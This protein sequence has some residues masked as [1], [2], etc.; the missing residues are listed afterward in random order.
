MRSLLV[1]LLTILFLALPVSAL[2]KPGLWVA[3]SGASTL[4]LFGTV[5]LLPGHTDW[6][7][8]ALDKALADSGTLYIEIT[9]DNPLSVQVLVLKYGIDWQNTLSSQLDPGDQAR[10][11]HVSAEAG[12]SLATLE[13]MR[14]WLAGLTLTMAPLLKAGLDPKQG[15]DKQLKAQFEAAGKPVKGLETSEQQIRFFA[16]MPPKLQ[17]KF[18]HGALKDYGKVRKELATLVGYWDAGDVAAIARTADLKMR[19]QSPALYRLLITERNHRWAAQLKKILATPG[20]YFVAVGTAHL[21]GPDSVQK[22]LE[23]LG[24]KVDRL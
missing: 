18:L 15:V 5:H 21:A 11:Q 12:L 23:K 10:L 19:R 8:P 22:Q 20:T 24:I 4:Y 6:R 13:H 16:D 3:H 1:R 14:P 17:L 9:D 7:Y 2:A